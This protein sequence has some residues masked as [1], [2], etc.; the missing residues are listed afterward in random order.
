MGAKQKTVGGGKSVGVAGDFA[1]QMMNWLSQGF[2]AV[3]GGQQTAGSNL[4]RSNPTG[5][6]SN[7]TEAFQAL[8]NGGQG[9]ANSAQ[10]IADIRRKSDVSDIRSRYALGGTGYGTPAASGEANFLAQ[11]DPQV[12]VGIGGMQMDGISKALSLL[13]PMFQ[14]Q[15]DKGTPG[16]QTVMQPS[17]FGN[18]LSGLG[19][20]VGAAAP[21]FGGGMGGGGGGGTFSGSPQ[22]GNS[23]AMGWN[24]KYFT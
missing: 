14:Q 7:L 6:V 12:A 5:Q 13:M 22:R 23:T 1:S 16:A 2:G 24:G 21:F 8:L 19:G 17:G 4:G 11:Y 3:P 10:Q 15:V 20:L 18:V 9:M